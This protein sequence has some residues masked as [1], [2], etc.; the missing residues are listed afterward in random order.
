MPEI[1]KNF[2]DNQLSLI[3][4]GN[5]THT[6]NTTNDYIRVAVSTLFEG[7]ELRFRDIYDSVNHDIS[8]YNKDSSIY[9]KPNEI[10]ESVSTPTGNYQLKFDFLRN[11]F[12]ENNGFPS[13]ITNT[14][15]S[16][17]ITNFYI[18]QISPSRKEIRLYAR[19]GD[20]QEV[21]F[22]DLFQS[23]FL[24][25][26]GDKEE[27]IENNFVLNLPQGV[28]VPII[29]YTF[30]NVSVNNKISLILR[31]LNPLPLT[32]NNL[33]TVSISQEVMQTQIQNIY[34]TSNIK[35]VMIG[36]GLTPDT[37]IVSEGYVNDTGNSFENYEDLITTGS[38]SNIDINKIL[39]ENE[40]NDVNLNIDYSD[41]NN[42]V[43]FGS[44]TSKLEN[45]VTKVK[46]I[47]QHLT[48]ISK[49]LSERSGSHVTNQREYLFNEIQ[50]IKN[51]FTPYEKFMY[52]D[53]QLTST[54]SAPGLG[55]NLAFQTPLN[56]NPNF[57]YA[58]VL[59]NYEG[60]SSVHKHD[61]ETQNTNNGAY[62][63]VRLFHKNY[64]VEKAPFHNYTGSVYLSFIIKGDETINSNRDS[65]TTESETT[66][67]K[68]GTLN[69]NQHH[70]IPVEAKFKTKVLSPVIT[71]SEYRYHVYHASQSHW[72]PTGSSTENEFGEFQTSAITTY[73]G[74]EYEILSNANSVFSASNSESKFSSYPIVT[75]TET[76]ANLGTHLTAS[77]IPFTGS[78]LPSGDLFDLRY[79]RGATNT[80]T[81]SFITDVRVTLNDPSNILPFGQLY[82]TS[83]T[84]W[85]EWYTQAQ[86]D[87]AEYDDK[88]IHSLKGNLPQFYKDND[89]ANELGTFTNMWGEQFDLLRNYIDNFNT[90]YKREYTKYNNAPTNILPVL[91]DNLGWELIN[92]FS[93]S[94]AEYYSALTG[95]SLTSKELTENIWKKEL[96]NLIYIYKSKGTLNSVRALLNIYGY[97]PDVISLNEQ[98]GSL[99]EHNPTVIDNALQEFR[100]GLRRTVGNI[101]YIEQPIK[102]TSMNF[103]SISESRNIA[104]SASFNE[105]F[106]KI[107]G[108]E[109][110]F[111]SPKTTHD[112]TLLFKSQSLF[113]LK[114]WDVRLVNSGSHPTRGKV[115]FRLSQK[116]G[117]GFTTLTT[118]A[119]SMSTDYASFKGT[120]WW[121]VLIQRMTGSNVLTQSYQ[122]LVAQ[123]EEDR[124]PKFYTASLTNVTD[125]STTDK[126]LA[127]TSSGKLV[128]G[129]RNFSG[130]LAEIRAWSGSLSASKFKQHVLNPINHTGNEIGDSW[131]RLVYR[132]RLAENV[133]SGSTVTLRDAN[134]SFNDDFSSTTSIK[135]Y[136]DLYNSELMTVY[137]LSTR[138]D[139]VNQK[140][141]NQIIFENFRTSVKGNLSPLKSVT[142]DKNDNLTKRKSSTVIDLR[143]SPTDTLDEIIIN[144]LSD[145]SISDSIGKVSDDNLT[146]N[147]YPDLKEIR[148]N[149]FKDVTVHIGDFI[150]AQEKN[151]IP[152]L[153]EKINQVTPVR[154]ETL[155]G[156][157]VKPTMLDRTKILRVSSSF[158]EAKIHTGD[159]AEF[160]DKFSTTSSLLMSESIYF[161]PQLG[162]IN[163]DTSVSESMSTA[164]IHPISITYN[165]MISESMTTESIHRIKIDHIPTMISYSM[166]TESFHDMN[167]DYINNMVSYSM[168]TES[169]HNMDFS[170]VPNFV[171]YSMATES[172]HRMNLDYITN[173]VSHSMAT[174]S[175]HRMNLDYVTDMVSHSMTTHSIH[176]IN[177]DHVPTM[178]SY[179]MATESFHDMNLN[180]VPNFVSYSMATESFHNISL[181][182]VSNM[183]SHSMTTESFHRLNLNYVTDMVSQSMTTE[184]I[185]RLNIGINDMISQSMITESIRSM[186]I[187]TNNM[188]SQSMTT[189]SMY[190]F[191]ILPSGKSLDNYDTFFSESM[192]YQIPHEG[193]SSFIQD[194]N[195][196]KYV[197]FNQ[198]WGKTIND[199]WLVPNIDRDILRSQ[200]TASDG[201]TNAMQWYEDDIVQYTIGDIEYFSASK[202]FV[203]CSGVALETGRTD[204][205]SE[206]YYDPTNH[207][208]HKN[209]RFYRPNRYTGD[210]G[211]ISFFPTSSRNG[212]MI[213]RTT[214][215]SESIDSNG[216][217]TI[218]YPSNHYKNYHLVKDQFRFLTYEKGPENTKAPQF[219]GSIDTQPTK[220]AYSKPVQGSDTRNVLRVERNKKKGGK[221]Y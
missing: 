56:T 212:R 53:N 40:Y 187:T 163:M 161:Q 103:N 178:V 95:S 98:G 165:N 116:A 113:G 48:E 60:F 198:G 34:Y 195:N 125:T 37:S 44:A 69:L 1:N 46:N 83:S 174:E 194:N 27:I 20:N 84:E 190:G 111:K 131:N 166:T 172:F 177:L 192:E 124:I 147:Y 42:H 152:F 17:F 121:N 180:Y 205:V 105:G 81:S 66:K 38:I 186:N 127:F 129:D 89:S 204:C 91:A 68:I 7:G 99:E 202:H 196:S 28:N 106:D 150:R 221:K 75:H 189:Q 107:D 88:N 18:N 168:T 109:F 134:P 10:L 31:L 70:S 151:H 214:Y 13:E 79:S 45:F 156:V 50:T 128:F 5:T 123:N 100:S 197:P 80:I 191:T 54:A 41:F 16:G 169:F 142:T 157:V 188:F 30:D 193:S 49:S 213:G 160:S 154:T 96:N 115:E 215:F 97:P 47:E 22:D 130:S 33:E 67:G 86:T 71:G 93:S 114:S 140:N 158:G 9:V 164:S 19:T 108:V 23:T 141:D 11:L 159:F 87:A 102:F 55:D 220:W 137:K 199:T 110:M 2:T 58:G 203:T 122:L 85:T 173:F 26:V 185:H 43:I 210:D 8:I 101:A 24:S 32:V 4:N 6:W 148:D 3:Q 181:D 182:Y 149:V 61:T 73:N 143:T 65:Q 112:Q 126:N 176:R 82:S 216:F 211:Y 15:E 135:N 77:G 39:S 120:G 153:L 104:P 183:V 207:E 218:H 21:I 57:G 94:L 179:S 29:N 63:D 133:S 139:A 52:Y 167:L 219:D 74:G 184:S 119:I 175:F 36:S 25:I 51:G 144:K 132:F 92:P 201:T 78:I 118:Q 200:H 136:G 208:H 90:F 170:Y 62:N 209:R 72:R 59:K 117:G 206:L 12:S 146:D 155:V 64:Q 14:F 138:T 145:Q 76:L 162:D 171:S 217:V 35:S